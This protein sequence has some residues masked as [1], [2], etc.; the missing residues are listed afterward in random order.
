LNGSFSGLGG[1]IGAILGGVL[2][3]HFGPVIMFYIFG[4][5][6]FLSLIWFLGTQYFLHRSEVCSLLQKK[7]IFDC[8]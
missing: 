6:V 3:D 4:G 8:S 7:Q 2:Y 1:S 5:G